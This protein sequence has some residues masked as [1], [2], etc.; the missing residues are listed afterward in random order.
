M[1]FNS[2]YKNNRK[3]TKIEKG[4]RTETRAQTLTKIKVGE[5]RK[6]EISTGTGTKR[7]IKS[8]SEHI[9]KESNRGQGQEEG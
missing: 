4:T 6:T 2:I 7:R 3:R 5:R 1:R 8:V 9:H